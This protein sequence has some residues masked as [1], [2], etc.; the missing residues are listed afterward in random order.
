MSRSG[1]SSDAYSCGARGSVDY[2]RT[3]GGASRLRLARGRLFEGGR[4]MPPRRPGLPTRG[5]ALAPPT[6]V[7]F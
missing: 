6:D 4:P 1:A 3:A 5:V 2:M 7:W